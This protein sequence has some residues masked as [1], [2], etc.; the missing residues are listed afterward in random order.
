M[1]D[2][3]TAHLTYRHHRT[4]RE[5][6]EELVARFLKRE[7]KLFEELRAGVSA[8]PLIELSSIQFEGIDLLVVTAKRRG[9]LLD[10]IRKALGAKIPTPNWTSEFS[11]TE[12]H[13]ITDKESFSL[14]E[15]VTRSLTAMN[16]TLPSELPLKMIEAGI[17]R[18]GTHEVDFDDLHTRVSDI[19]ATPHF[20]QW[21]QDKLSR[22]R[23]MEQYG[24]GTRVFLR[25]A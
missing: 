23:S 1:N 7:R 24:P 19:F 10:M 13:C 15:S 2:L 18:E 12:P 5:M 17:V 8:L 14:E 22:T 6:L 21:R 25:A 11:Y 4:T 16:H 20:L 9:L 3:T